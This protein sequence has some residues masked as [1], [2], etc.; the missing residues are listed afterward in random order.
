MER[1][2]MTVRIE[3][4]FHKVMTLSGVEMMLAQLPMLLRSIM[5]V[6]D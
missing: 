1:D 3:N 4:T 2:R 5:Y 6:E